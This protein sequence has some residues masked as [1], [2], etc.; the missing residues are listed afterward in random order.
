MAEARPHQAID[1]IEAGFIARRTRPADVPAAFAEALLTVAGDAP[2]PLLQRAGARIAAAVQRI[3]SHGRVPE[4]HNRH[5]ASEA[6]LAMGHLCRLAQ[7]QGLISR[8]DAQVGVVAMVG[9]DL[10]HDGSSQG[11]GVLEARS[12]E[13]VRAI[14][15][16]AGAGARDL[17]AIGDIILATDPALVAANAARPLDRPCN[18]LR[19]LANEADVCASLL[20]T[21]GPCLSRLLAEEWRPA[22]DP[23]LLRVGT[24]AGRLGFLLGYPPLSPAATTLGLGR[25][26]ARCLEVYAEAARRLGAG[27]TSEQG[28]AALDSLPEA[29]SQAAYAEALA[30]ISP[31]V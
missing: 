17:A 6:T 12:W 16:E 4:Y 8:H 30:L 10:D 22:N 1:A 29:A 9:H 24:A 23:M 5:H 11:G 13:A 31:S 19:I 28:C 26:R 3:P 18:A 27:S 15:A 14:A 21:L 20:P 25:A 2:D 7:A